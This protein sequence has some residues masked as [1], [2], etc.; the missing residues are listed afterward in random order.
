MKQ[1]SGPGRPPADQVLKDIRRQTRLFPGGVSLLCGLLIARHDGVERWWWMCWSHRYPAPWYE[2]LAQ[3][4]DDPVALVP[5][6]E[7]ILS[8]CS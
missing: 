2:S 8:S 1:K 4:P 5:Q 6:V 7:V 3:L